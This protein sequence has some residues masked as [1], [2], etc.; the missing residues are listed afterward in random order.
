MRSRHRRV[1]HL[2]SVF[3]GGSGAA[4][5]RPQS[6]WAVCGRFRGPRL[7]R[8]RVPSSPLAPAAPSL[9][10]RRTR[11]RRRARRRNIAVADHARTHSVTMTTRGGQPKF[12]LKPFKQPAKVDVA[13]AVAM[14]ER[15]RSAIVNIQDCAFQNLSFEELYRCAR[16]QRRR[17]SRAR[18]WGRGGAAHVSVPRR[19][20]SHPGRPQLVRGRGARIGH[21][22]RSA[23]SLTSLSTTRCSGCRSS[24]QRHSV[25]NYI[26]RASPVHCPWLC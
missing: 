5:T 16:M 15:L 26:A 18:D 2:T 13:A 17:S 10:R 3:A 4:V 1:A 24:A 8:R 25:R 20:C 21:H 14:W 12:V 9:L 7:V 11:C 19:A 22:Q 23:C 6:V